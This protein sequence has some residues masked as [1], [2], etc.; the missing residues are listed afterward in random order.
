MACTPTLVNAQV[1]V[2]MP[3]YR[4]YFLDARNKITEP[5]CQVNCA[6]DEDV[7]T[8]AAEM[9]GKYPPAIEI[10]DEGR[11]VGRVPVA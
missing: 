1:E 3:I 11:I 6:T 4:L 10:W 5:A 2:L 9:L 7:L 8:T